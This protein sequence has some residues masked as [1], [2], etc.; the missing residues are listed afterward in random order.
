[1]PSCCLA[2]QR[3]LSTGSSSGVSVS[4]SGSRK[5][6]S[7][8]RALPR[9][10]WLDPVT[11]QG[12]FQLH[13]TFSALP[14][15]L[16]L[17]AFSDFSSPQRAELRKAFSEHPALARGGV[18][19]CAPKPPVFSPHHSILSLWVRARPWSWIAWAQALAL[20]LASSVTL[21]ELLNLHVPQFLHLQHGTLSPWPDELVFTENS[22]W[23]LVCAIGV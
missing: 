4:S 10:Q 18:H 13:G 20:P 12:A 6:G 23:S 5:R 3:A 17:N 7:W 15:F 21:G 9:G 22:V 8:F 11:S 19:P 16:W 1:M 14:T 2:S